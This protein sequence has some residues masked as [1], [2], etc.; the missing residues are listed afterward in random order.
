[1]LRVSHQHS[2]DSGVKVQKGCEA[3]GVKVTDIHVVGRSARVVQVS[4]PLAK[5]ALEENSEVT[6]VKVK[7]I[8]L[9]PGPRPPPAGNVPGL[10]KNPPKNKPCT[11]NVTFADWNHWIHLNAKDNTHTQ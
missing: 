6:Q 3:F 4:K 10:K 9:S 5:M 2:Y 11:Q 7:V 1:M 8:Q